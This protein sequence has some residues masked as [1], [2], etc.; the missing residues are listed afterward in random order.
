MKPLQVF[1][2]THTHT[3]T[4]TG[5]LLNKKRVILLNNKLSENNKLYYKN[6]NKIYLNKSA[7]ITIISLIVTII[8]LLILAG[9]SI[10]T[11]TSDNGIIKQSKSAKEKTE[12]SEEKEAIQK[13]VIGAIGTN[14]RGN[15]EESELQKQLDK[16]F[17]TDKT[18]LLDA[19]EE[20]DISIKNT[21]RYYI[22]D[23]DGNIID[24]CEIIKDIYPGDITRGK[25]GEI[26]D[27][28]EE[29]PYEI[30]CIEDLIAFS[31]IVNATGIKYVDNKPV[32][33]T[34]TDAFGEKYVKL[35]KNLNFKSK[36]SYADSERTDFGNLN[37][38]DNDGDKLINEMK[39][40]TGFPPIGRNYTN[41]YRI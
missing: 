23:K 21:N 15:L 22:L 7:G 16:E 17:G 19:G 9:I 35:M 33:I 25:D 30:W 10:A 18:T 41:V 1:T 3:H 13:A 12:I 27:G 2:H 34:R 26:L 28:S 37:G 39:T 5:H 36:F 14:K 11:L 29:H 6:N 38:I 24:S 20:F 31:N 40:G 32:E 4:H 8:V